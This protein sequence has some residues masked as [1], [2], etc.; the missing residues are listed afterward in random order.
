MSWIVTFT[1]LI[2][3]FGIF[4]RVLAGPDATLF[5]SGIGQLVSLVAPLAIAGAFTVVEGRPTHWGLA[6]RFRQSWHWYLLATI[7]FPVLTV[8]IVGFGHIQGSLF[9]QLEQGLGKFMVV[10][11]VAI[12]MAFVKNI[13]EELT[14]RGYLYERLVDA[15][16]GRLY[17][18]LIV[19]VVWALWHLPF[20]DILVETYSDVPVQ[21]YGPLFIIALVVSS[22][23]CGEIR[24][25]SKTVWTIVILHTMAN[26]AA[27]GFIFGGVVALERSKLWIASPVPDNLA[28]IAVLSIT[29]IALYKLPVQRRE[30]KQA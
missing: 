26:A 24:Q 19:G 28:Y 30:N 27:A 25:R 18:H 5:N 17:N 13:I 14:W 29:A 8:L 22:I 4:G 1:A 9:L 2:L 3:V 20:L 16:V 12:P 11:A 10:T 15:N 7:L 23:V 6:P 21:I